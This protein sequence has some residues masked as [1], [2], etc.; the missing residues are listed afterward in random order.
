MKGKLL[1][2]GAGMYGVV[3]K[4]IAQSTNR[5]SQIDFLDDFASQ[6]LDG[7]PVIGTLMDL[8]NFAQQYMGVVI[9]IGSSEIRL[10]MLGFLED[11][12][13]PLVTLI[14]PY[15]YI[16]PSARIESGAVIEPMAVIH[17]GCV[18]ERGCIISAGA[19]VNHFS[20]C[21]AGVHVDCNATVAGNTI[22]PRNTKV[23]SG[24][25]YEEK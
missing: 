18:I 12:G 3:A 21:R 2:L 11:A 6:T 24:T 1:I 7:D 4:E 13:I 5:F 9:A 23:L 22:V 16:S 15:A 8:D 20:T 19:V 14:S 10:K 17:S 25:C